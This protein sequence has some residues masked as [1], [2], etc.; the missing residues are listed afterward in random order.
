MTVFKPMQLVTPVDSQHILYVWN[1][2]F[3]EFFQF[4][5]LSNGPILVDEEVG[6]T[7][8]YLIWGCTGE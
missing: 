4:H 7:E 2:C 6:G 3:D 5:Y 1:H 8:K